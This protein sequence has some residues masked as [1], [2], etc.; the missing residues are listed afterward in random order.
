MMANYIWAKDP[1]TLAVRAKCI[2]CGT[3]FEVL[4]FGKGS[5]GKDAC[6]CPW[7]GKKIEYDQEVD[8]RLGVE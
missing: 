7:C 8:W 1:H 6:H 5:I 3:D 4:Y 2:N